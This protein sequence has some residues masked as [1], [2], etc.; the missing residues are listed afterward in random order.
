MS[1]AG[2]L[3]H[4]T[5]LYGTEAM[6]DSQVR[7]WAV[8]LAHL[9]LFQGSVGP[10]VVFI[11]YQTADV[12]QLLQSEDGTCAI[13]DMPVI[14]M[15][16]IL[17]QNCKVHYEVLRANANDRSYGNRKHTRLSLSCLRYHCLAFVITALPSLSLPC[18]RYHC[19]AFVITALPQLSLPCLSYHCLASVIIAL[20]Q[21]SLPCLSYH[22]LVSV[23]IALP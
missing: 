19:L 3:R 21:L 16:C 6:S 1:A 2:I 11:G 9:R 15:V 8:T 5:K 10:D 17:F 20:P 4:A 22:C 23:I 14:K 18:L 7:K 12:Q 13:H